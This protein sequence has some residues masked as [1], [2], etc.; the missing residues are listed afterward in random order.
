MREGPRV[1]VHRLWNMTAFDITLVYV[2]EDPVQQQ[3]AASKVLLLCGAC[4]QAA[5]LIRQA[6][7]ERIA[8]RRKFAEQRGRCR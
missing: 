7:F 5:R 8:G 1:V 6:E 4:E 3:R 2:I